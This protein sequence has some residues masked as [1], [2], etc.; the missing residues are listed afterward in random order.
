MKAYTLNEMEN[1]FEIGCAIQSLMDDHLITHY[2]HREMFLKAL[3]WAI[4][5]E[6]TNNDTEDYFWDINEFVMN[7]CKA[8]GMMS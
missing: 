2:N 5:F 1:I 6:K 4:E 8:D 3:T 7:K